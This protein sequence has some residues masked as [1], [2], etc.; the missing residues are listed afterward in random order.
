[1]RFHPAGN[2]TVDRVATVDALPS[3]VDTCLIKAF[4]KARIPRFVGSEVSIG[5]LIR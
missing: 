1:M 5:F 2:A 3:D 4:S